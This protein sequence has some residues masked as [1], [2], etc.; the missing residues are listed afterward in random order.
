MQRIDVVI[1]YYKQQELWK[2]VLA[3]LKANERYIDTIYVVN[4]EPWE[5]EL[6]TGGL[7]IVQLEHPHDG[8]G[9]CRSFN[10]GVAIA[11]AEYVLLT[12]ADC[13]MP[14]GYLR[15]RINACKP[16]C[17]VAGPVSHIALDNFV[18]PDPVVLRT[19][20]FMHLVGDADARPWQYVRG[21]TK[22]VHHDSYLGHN[23]LLNER[24]YEDWEFTARWCMTYGDDSV[25]YVDHSPMW[26]LGDNKA[27]ESTAVPEKSY[28]ILLDT[29][30]KYN[31]ARLHRHASVIVD[32]DDLCDATVDSL[33]LLDKLKQAH[34]ALKVTL[35]AIPARCSAQTIALA[36]SL[37]AK[38]GGSWLQLAPHGW[39]HTRG[40]CLGWGEEEAFIKIKAAADKGIDAP[41]FKAPAW[42]LDGDVYATCRRMNYI[43]YNPG[44]LGITN[45]VHGHLTPTTGNYIQDMYK[46]GELSFS[47]TQTFLWPQEVV[48]AVATT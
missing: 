7:D 4:D 31:T 40:E 48:S 36:K 47:P 45:Y 6:P 35:F 21:A 27:N 23:E 28:A 1:G 38:H 18:Y 20:S 17:L 34:P 46:R 25:I 5:Y 24:N 43:V 32:F 37:D 2:H 26:H 29:L 12:T 39:R 42:L 30:N 11:R 8:F 33:L 14:P 41:L 9:L 16:K 15:G 13:V 19:D 22:L 10:Q 44:H 3:G